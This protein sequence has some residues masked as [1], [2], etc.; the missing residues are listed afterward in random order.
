MVPTPTETKRSLEDKTNSEKTYFA[1][2][3]RLVDDD[4]NYE[5]H[6]VVA[7][8]C[9]SDSRAIAFF[10]RKRLDY[11]GKCAEELEKMLYA[12]K[13]NIR[14]FCRFY[15]GREPIEITHPAEIVERMNEANDS[16]Y[17]TDTGA[18][19]QEIRG[20]NCEKKKDIA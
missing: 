19:V 16:M 6:L 18:L 10:S 17:E 12:S 13:R 1:A 14:N 2:A 8:N 15:G 9:S 11:P 3:I 5:G 4:G 7:K 20:T